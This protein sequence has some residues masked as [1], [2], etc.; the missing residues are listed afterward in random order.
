M[1]GL[2]AGVVVAVVWAGSASADPVLVMQGAMGGSPPPGGLPTG[3][4]IGVGD[5]VTLQPFA[6]IFH[7]V[8]SSV[9]IG[10]IFTATSGDA[11]N[12]FVDKL[13]NGVAD[14]LWLRVDGTGV[15]GSLET[16]LVT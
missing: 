1:K 6:T 14:E 5:A 3:I 4:S 11:Y 8:Y 13:T 15:A 10:T 16:H 7:R 9:D 12:I 2:I